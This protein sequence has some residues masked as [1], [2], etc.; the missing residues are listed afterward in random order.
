MKFEDLKWKAHPMAEDMMTLPEENRKMFGAEY[1]TARQ[2][3]YTAK[4]GVEFSI[5]FGSLFYSNGI[6]TY[7]IWVMND[8]LQ[9][10]SGY[11]NPAGYLTADEIVAYIEKGCEVFEENF[12]EK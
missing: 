1:L 5:L 10:V 7:E 4:C 9:G 2:A 8:L 12:G 3:R 11:E 6:N